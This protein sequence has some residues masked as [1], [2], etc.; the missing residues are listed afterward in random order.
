M[1]DVA[2][3]AALIGHY[4]LRL[5]VIPT[6][7]GMLRPTSSGTHTPAPRVRVLDLRASCCS[8][9]STVLYPRS[10]PHCL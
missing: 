7:L 9:V 3:T 2:T 8:N 5:F 1:I 4:T 6:D 10:L